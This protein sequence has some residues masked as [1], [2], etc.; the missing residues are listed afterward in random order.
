M[1][2]HLAQREGFEPSCG[3]PQTD[4][5]FC[6]PNAICAPP[7]SKQA[8]SSRPFWPHHADFRRIRPQNRVGTSKS[9]VPPFGAKSNAFREKCKTPC[10][11]TGRASG[12]PGR[13]LAALSQ[14]KIPP[15]ARKL[16]PNPGRL[17]YRCRSQSATGAFSMIFPIQW[18]ALTLDSLIRPDQGSGFTSLQDSGFPSH[19]AIDLKV[20]DVFIHLPIRKINPRLIGIWPGLFPLKLQIIFADPKNPPHRGQIVSV[21]LQG[22]F[23]RV[24]KDRLFFWV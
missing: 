13:V 3:C 16:P 6:V 4:F 1:P 9:I 15:Q 10:K 11:I 17:P 20:H 2:P 14:H 22:G 21:P 24:T 19:S 23:N 18:L 7:G 8:V 12:P 5:E